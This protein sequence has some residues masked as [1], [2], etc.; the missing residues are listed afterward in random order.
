MDFAT[1]LRRFGLFIIVIA[2]LLS[3]YLLQVKMVHTN[4]DTSSDPDYLPRDVGS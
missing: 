4:L 1:L 3:N 2:A